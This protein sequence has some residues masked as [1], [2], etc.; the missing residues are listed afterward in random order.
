MTN[1][2]LGYS[3]LKLI[4][5]NLKLGIVCLKLFSGNLKLGTRI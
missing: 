2:K 3:F 5:G 1:V 4:T